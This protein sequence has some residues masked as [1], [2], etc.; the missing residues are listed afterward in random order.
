M[1]FLQVGLGSMGK[2][3]I[4]CLKAL[5]EDEI[6][7]FDLKEDRRKEAESKYNIKTF[8]SF[9]E[10]FKVN[11]D[12]LIISTPPDLHSYYALIAAKEG[13]HFFTEASVDNRDYDEIIKYINEKNI[14]G[15]PSCTLRFNYLIKKIKTL[16]DEN[17]IGKILAF[18]YHSG[19]YLPDWH[20]WEDYRNFYVSKRE[21]GACR[22]IVPFELVWL[23]W[24]FGELESLSCF[25]DKLT[26]LETEIDDIYQILLKFKS[27]TIGHLLVDVIS[28]I[29]YRNCRILSEEGVIEMDWS[30][31]QILI[32]DAKNKLLEKYNEPEGKVEEGYIHSENMYIAEIEKFLKAIK[33]IE[34]FGYSFEEDKKILDILYKAEESSLKQKHIKI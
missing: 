23:L 7:G 32:Y 10:S 2:R 15:V 6:Y 17:K 34:P 30:K 33:G 27:G 14:V 29:P 4:R 11:P 22:E 18:T 3:R 9:D 5:G 1:K 8:S 20:P 21:T 12:V 16:I 26:K 19:Q 31:K 28:R 13:K 24:V 25:K